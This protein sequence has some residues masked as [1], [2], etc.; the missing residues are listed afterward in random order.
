MTPENQFKDVRLSRI[1]SL[2]ANAPT[3]AAARTRTGC[4]KTDASLIS[5]AADGAIVEAAE[6]LATV[7]AII[8]EWRMFCDDPLITEKQALDAL[9]SLAIMTGEIISEARDIDVR[10]GYNGG[11][12]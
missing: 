10:T 2:L 1:G 12:A 7:A 5:D 6:T 4:S 11:A 8:R 3:I 9:E